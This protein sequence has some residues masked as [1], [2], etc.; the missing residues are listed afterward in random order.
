MLVPGSLFTSSARIQRGTTQ[1]TKQ[2]YNMYTTPA[3][4]LR[5]WSNIVQVLYKCFMFA[6]NDIDGLVQ[7]QTIQKNN[8]CNRIVKNRPSEMFSAAFIDIVIISSSNGSMTQRCT[9]QKRELCFFYTFISGIE[10]LTS[11]VDPRPEIT[12]R[13]RALCMSGGM[14]GSMAKLKYGPQDKVKTILS[15]NFLTGIE[16]H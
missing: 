12:A 7:S 10:S 2:L 9:F 1:Q 8:H 5:R 13:R 14:S 16:S 4:R 15:H 3:Q 6:V 11:K